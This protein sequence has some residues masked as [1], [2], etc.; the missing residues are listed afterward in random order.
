MD[1]ASRAVVSGPCGEVFDA[2]RPFTQAGEPVRVVGTQRN[3]WQ[4]FSVFISEKSLGARVMYPWPIGDCLDTLDEALD[5]A[6]DY[7]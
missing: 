4:G 3:A 2:A 5:I 1:P 6:M 7:P